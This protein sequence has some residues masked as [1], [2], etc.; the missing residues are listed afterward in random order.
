MQ[1]KQV[2]RQYTCPELPLG[3]RRSFRE[4]G[5][6]SVVKIGHRQATLAANAG[7]SGSLAIIGPQ[8][9]LPGELITLSPPA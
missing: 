5:A 4:F 6:I 1:A 8:S 3:L 7:I 2:Q 9:N